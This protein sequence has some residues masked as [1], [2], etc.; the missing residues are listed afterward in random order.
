MILD[1]PQL[2]L[3]TLP[4]VAGMALAFLLAAGTVSAA[5][6]DGFY[7]PTELRGSVKL[8]GR[9]YELP[10]QPL[11]RALLDKGVVPVTNNRIPVNRVRWAELVERF[12]FR[13]IGGKAYAYGPSNVVLRKSGKRFVGRTNT[14]L[15]VKQ[16]GKYKFVSV[17]V[18]MRT[19]LP[20][21]IKDDVLT[22]NA[23]IEFS[24][25]G[26][27]AKG[28]IVLEATKVETPPIVVE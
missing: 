28:S 6:A 8:F 10:L 19:N 27:T 23:P 15:L 22:M 14:P 18:T 4:R 25:L 20:T 26:V 11:R 21:V 3:R 17:T 5:G 12:K 7:K 2:R 9:T 16:K 1:P 24:A 13:D